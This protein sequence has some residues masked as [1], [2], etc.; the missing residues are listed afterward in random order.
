[1]SEKVNTVHQADVCEIVC[2]DEEKVTR[3][4]GQIEEV[5]GVELLFKAL[6]DSTRIK[7][8][9]ALT[10][11][12][13]LCVCDVANII[14]SSTATASHHLRLLRNMGLAKYRKEGKLVF[15]SL[16]D[17]HVHQLVSIALIH[18]KEG[19]GDGESSR[20]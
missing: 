14:G 8:A 13:E 16:E 3:V 12:K 6:A 1:M 5:N 2:H 18:S 19:V 7:I 11:E 4:K 20:K 17:E 15:Y 10:L 9:Y